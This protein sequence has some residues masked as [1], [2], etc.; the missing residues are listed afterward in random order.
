MAQL[1][2]FEGGVDSCGGPVYVTCA[3]SVEEA[4]QNIE[5]DIMSQWT[6]VPARA[7]ELEKLRRMQPRI[8]R[9]A[10]YYIGE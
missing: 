8:C 2:L 7:E 9:A 1:Y 6:Y 10:E 4:L 5:Q 3:D